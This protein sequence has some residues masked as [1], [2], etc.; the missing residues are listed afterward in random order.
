MGAFLSGL[1]TMFPNN[2]TVEADFSLIGYEKDEYRNSLTEFSL[3]GILH[4]KP[5]DTLRALRRKQ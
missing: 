4:A 1:A 2:A 5:F 3:E